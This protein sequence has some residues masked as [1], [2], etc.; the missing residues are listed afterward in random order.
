MTVAALCRPDASRPEFLRWL[1]LRDEP[2]MPERRAVLR[3]AVLLLLVLAVGGSVGCSTVKSVGRATG[4]YF[5]YRAEDLAEVA[6]IGVS[7]TKKPTIGL[8]AC[9]AS[10]ICLGYCNIDGHMLGMGGG[11]VGLMGLTARCYGAT[12]TGRE[13]V[14]WSHGPRIR[15]YT[16]PMGLDAVLAAPML[17]PPAYCPACTHYL[18]F[19]YIGLVA[20]L[21]YAEMLD[22][23]LGFTTFDLAC[24][25]GQV[26]GRWFFQ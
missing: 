20:N 10:I 6:D 1:S 23:I 8:Y 24:D 26:M 13:Y 22:F 5:K 9:F 3:A 12:Y 11:Q 14:L 18:H 25:D 15:Q 4:R 21:K 19:M 17:P 2:I 7:L 16:H